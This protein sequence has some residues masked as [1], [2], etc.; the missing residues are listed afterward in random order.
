MKYCLEEVLNLASHSIP[1]RKFS[2][3]VCQ[4]VNFADGKFEAMDDPRNFYFVEKIV[5][6]FREA[7]Q[8]VYDPLPYMRLENSLQDTEFAFVPLMNQLPATAGTSDATA[9]LSAAVYQPEIF[10]DRIKMNSQGLTFYA[11]VRLWVLMP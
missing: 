11:A 3:G 5:C 4:I 9:N 7:T 10:A 1:E 8:E 6:G 2:T